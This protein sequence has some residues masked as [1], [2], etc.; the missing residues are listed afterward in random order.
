MPYV[1]LRLREADE[2]WLDSV[3]VQVSSARP[4]LELAPLLDTHATTVGHY[5]RV[6]GRV[7]EENTPKVLSA[8]RRAAKNIPCFTL[9]MTGWTVTSEGCVRCCYVLAGASPLC[10]P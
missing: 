6:C 2:K 3:G 8:V 1:R 4:D 5:V 10:C 7:K 9:A